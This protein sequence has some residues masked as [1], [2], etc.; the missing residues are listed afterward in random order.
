MSINLPSIYPITDTRIS[1]L[2]HA[3]QVSRLIAGG[4][5]FIQLR[6]KHAAPRGFMNDALA[7]L[8][9]ARARGTSLIIN[10]RVDIAL[11]IGAD[12]VHLGQSDIPASYARRLLGDQRIIGFSTH[13]LDQVAAALEL[14]IDYL[15]FGPVYSTSTKDKPDPTVG[16]ALLREAS[17]LAHHLPL[18][19]I[20]GISPSNLRET[21][22]AG[23]DSVAVISSVLSPGSQ[24][25]ENL[26]NLTSLASQTV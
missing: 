18:V 25:T 14:P 7:A 8:Q 11:A 19:A 13:N 9:L 12:G 23:A 21:L 15:A 2:S 6:E 16:L 22:T 3:E 10:D 1:G 17:R 20:G 24:I 5:T 26:R 4:A